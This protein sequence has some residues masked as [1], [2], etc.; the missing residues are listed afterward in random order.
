[1]LAVAAWLLV[2]EVSQESATQA[3]LCGHAGVFL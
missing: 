3:L 2:Q 1:M